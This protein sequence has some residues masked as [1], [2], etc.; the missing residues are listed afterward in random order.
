MYPWAYRGVLHQLWFFSFHVISLLSFQRHADAAK[1]SAKKG[2][3]S[4][5]QMADG[6]ESA[7]AKLPT[8][9]LS[10]AD[11]I[12][13]ATTSAARC[14]ALLSLAL[15]LVPSLKHGEV[16]L[17]QVSLSHIFAWYPHA[18]LSF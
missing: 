17:E 5:S 12:Q 1:S 8:S 9:T 4:S 15:A 10:V 6:D 16:L 18:D 3:P 13:Q 7:A 2:L 14:S 11:A